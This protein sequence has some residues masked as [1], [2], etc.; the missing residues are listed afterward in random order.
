VLIKTAAE[1]VP[2]LQQALQALHPY[3]GAWILLL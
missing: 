2:A 3:E 1:C